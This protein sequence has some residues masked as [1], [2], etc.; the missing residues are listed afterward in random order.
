MTHGNHNA[1][2]V[3]G[4]LV[5]AGSITG[6][7]YLGAT[8]L[9]IPRQLPPAPTAFVGRAPELSALTTALGGNATVAITALAGTGGIGKTALALHWAHQRIADFPDGQLFVDLRGFSPD[10]DPLTPATAVRGFLDALGQDPAHQPADPFA[11]YRSLVAG[12]RLLII[13]DN[14]VDTAQVLPLLPGSPTCTVLVTSRNHLP[15][16]IGAHGAQ[17]VALDVLPRPDAHELLATRLGHADPADLRELGELCGGLPL[18]LNIVAGR[19]RTQPHLPLSEVI[20]ELRDTGLDEDDPTASVTA[21]LSWSHR[22]LGTEAARVFGLLGIAPG[23]DI[24]LTAATALTGSPDTRRTLRALEQASLVHRDANNRWRM[25]DLV[26]NFAA[27]TATDRDLGGLTDFYL[28]TALAAHHHLDQLHVLPLPPGPP[29]TPPLD[30]PDEQS[31]LAWFDAEHR[32]LFDTVRLDD[33]PL[34]T[35][36]L[37]WALTTYQQRRGHQALHLMTWGLGLVAADYLDHP[38]ARYTALRLLG[39]ASLRL[40][41]PQQALDCL[42]RA[43]G[44]ATEAGDL[45]GQAHAQRALA[46]AWQALGD[47]Q[48]ALEAA[49]HA[50]DAFEQLGAPEWRAK[51]LKGYGWHL[52]NLGLELKAVD[53]FTTALELSR[54]HHYRDGEAGALHSLGSIALKLGRHH[55]AIDY[56]HQAL[57]QYRELG[58]AYEQADILRRLGSAH[59]ALGQ[60][61]QAATAW[62]E[63][64]VLHRAQHREQQVAWLLARLGES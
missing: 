13:L 18:A 16:L 34:L 26:R 12:K 38:E 11:H 17:H 45:A 42:R 4:H 21:V 46:L 61:D 20:A 51:A 49:T 43:V 19:A 14:A 10:S 48:Q 37:A 23:P 28:H 8:P 9:P 15:G 5:Q 33:N 27:T 25:H 32:A 39:R 60:T 7:I 40:G 36:Q 35:W 62:R 31:A 3:G 47:H 57:T 55:D 22:A 58:D 24:S 41:H 54:V 30:M 59:T 64:L 50:L 44:L 2:S 1:G 56:L 52:A 53:Y 6:D 29:R 63:S